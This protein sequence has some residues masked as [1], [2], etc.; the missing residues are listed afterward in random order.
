MIFT[1]RPRTTGLVLAALIYW[2]DQ[3]IKRMVD[4]PWGLTI[5][6]MH[7]DLLPFFS[8]TRTHN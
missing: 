7:M 5:E 4:G 6:G 3:W 1:A 8:L 2:V